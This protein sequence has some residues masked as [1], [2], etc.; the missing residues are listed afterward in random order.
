MRIALL[1]V[2]AAVVVGFLMARS[3]GP[4]VVSGAPNAPAVIPVS[5]P[6][7]EPSTPAAA[8]LATPTLQTPRV[9]NP[10]VT[11]KP[12]ARAQPIAGAK[13]EN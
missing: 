1:F 12:S 4:V 3:R 6:A 13:S 9:I 10:V 5:E 8:A 2:V 11:K 7:A